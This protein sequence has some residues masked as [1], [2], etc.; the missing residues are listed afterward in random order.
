M[1]SKHTDHHMLT[2]RALERLVGSKQV[3]DYRIT[4][5]ASCSYGFILCPDEDMAER[6]RGHYVR[7]GN[8][9]IFFDVISSVK[10]MPFDDDINQHPRVM[11]MI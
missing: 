9:K 8:D 3:L 2:I 1:D 11:K 7:V 4:A 5:D 6:L 10:Y